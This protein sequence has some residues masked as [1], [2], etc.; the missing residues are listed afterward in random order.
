MALPPFV[1]YGTERVILCSRL[2]N[3]KVF[4]SFSS[5]AK[6]AV[7]SIPQSTRSTSCMED[8]LCSNSSKE[9]LYENMRRLPKW[10]TLKS[11]S[12]SKNTS[13]GVAGEA[14]QSPPT[15][16]QSFST[17]EKEMYSH[18]TLLV[19]AEVS[20]LSSHFRGW[21]GTK[22]SNFIDVWFS[23]KQQIT[24]IVAFWFGPESKHVG[25]KWFERDRVFGIEKYM[26]ETHTWCTQDGDDNS[27]LWQLFT[28]SKV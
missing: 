1:P 28:K 25:T 13:K 7:F 12:S 19:K 8:T 4:F 21:K 11:I 27:S 22:K 10:Y 9:S 5:L 14:V 26:R 16:S 18:S 23:K 20:I 17:S 6:T 24:G 2:T 3:E 15:L